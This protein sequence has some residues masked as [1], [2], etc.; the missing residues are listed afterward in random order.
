MKIIHCEKWWLDSICCFTTKTP[1][2]YVALCQ[3]GTRLCMPCWCHALSH[4]HNK[5]HE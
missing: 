1:S 3:W 5:C 2:T 4:S